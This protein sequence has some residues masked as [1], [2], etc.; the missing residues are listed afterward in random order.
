MRYILWVGK[1]KEAGG[2]IN[3]NVGIYGVEVNLKL[4]YLFGGLLKT[5]IYKL[6]IVD[7]G[8]IS[9]HPCAVSK[10]YD[11]MTLTCVPTRGMV[12]LL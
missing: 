10:T 7:T 2:L 11:P 3:A 8:C 6:L 12:T 9:F 4:L 5:P 1:K